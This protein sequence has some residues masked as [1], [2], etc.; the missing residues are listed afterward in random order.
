MDSEQRFEDK[1]R[2]R[3][4]VN[5]RVLP[6]SCEA[7]FGAFTNPQL[8]KEWW[9]PNGFSNTFHE[10]DLKPGGAW[11]FTM[12]APDGAAYEN[13]CQ[14][15]EIKPFERIVIDHIEPVHSFRLI[16]DITR[17]RMGTEL[18]F[19]MTFA[20]REEYERVKD[21][22][23]AANEQNFDRLEAVLQKIKLTG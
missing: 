1:N 12:H 7:V 10:F 21:F 4:I 19:N 20:L 5:A 14:F 22:V 16:A 13:F 17:T 3:S 8:L 11:R 2:E 15:V 23:R 18:K 9:G 6:F